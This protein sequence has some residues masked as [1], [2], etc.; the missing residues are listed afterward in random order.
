M[1]LE[2]ARWQS[3]DV[4]QVL[5]RERRA[6]KRPQALSARAGGVN[7]VSFC[8]RALRGHISER[9]ERAISSFDAVE[10][11]L[12]DLAGAHSARPDRCGDCLGRSVNERGGHAVKTGAG[13]C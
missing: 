2:P 12:G 5:D 3:F 4:E 9:A 11:L 8:E 7:R 13:S 6:G 1:I 10:R